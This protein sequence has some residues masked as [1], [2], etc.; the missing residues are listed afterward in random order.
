MQKYGKRVRE[1]RLSRTLSPRV[2]PGGNPWRSGASIRRERRSSSDRRADSAS[3]SR[4][5][6]PLSLHN[7]GGRDRFR[8][9]SLIFAWEK[10]RER[11]KCG[12]A[13]VAAASNKVYT[14]QKRREASGFI[15]SRSTRR[16]REAEISPGIQQC[17][18]RSR[19]PPQ[20]GWE[21]KDVDEKSFHCRSYPT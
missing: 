6:R 16:S 17:S 12:A 11:K 7:W 5:P 20:T 13:A 19:A 15:S 2:R 4:R 9:S 3:S 1:G 21:D 8:I 10:E 14:Y 18:Q